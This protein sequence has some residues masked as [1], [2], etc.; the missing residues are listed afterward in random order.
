MHGFAYHPNISDS[1]RDDSN[2][3][4]ITLMAVLLF[5]EPQRYLLKNQIT[6]S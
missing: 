6:L 5:Q 3:L 1:C 2:L 4:H